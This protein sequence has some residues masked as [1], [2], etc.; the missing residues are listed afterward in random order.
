[1]NKKSLE[2]L[3][4]AGALDSLE[5]RA[6]MLHNLE[7]LLKFNKEVSKADKNQDSL[8]GGTTEE[9]SHLHLEKAEPIPPEQKLAWEKSIQQSF[10]ISHS[11]FENALTFLLA[12]IS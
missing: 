8:F 9:V 12:L 3:I 6:L 4:K 1:M 2:A 10:Q 5:D 7:A 11:N